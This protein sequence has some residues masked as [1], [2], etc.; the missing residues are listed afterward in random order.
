MFLKN[1]KQKSYIITYM[2]Q[3]LEDS[4][5]SSVIVKIAHKMDLQCIE[6]IRKDIMLNNGFD[7]VAI[8]SI[9]KL[10]D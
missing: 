6:N 2:Q 9:S 10:D 7:D 4:S 5:I 8:I 3:T 1:K